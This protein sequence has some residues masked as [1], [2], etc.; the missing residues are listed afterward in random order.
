MRRFFYQANFCAECGNALPQQRA[1]R[2]RYFCAPCAQQ[3]R[4]HSLRYRVLLPLGILLVLGSWLVV[5]Q[6]AFSHDISPPANSSAVVTAWDATAQS[7]PAQLSQPETAQPAAFCGARTKRGTPCRRLVQAG[8]RC[9]Q[10]RGKPSLLTA[11][12]TNT[13]FPVVSEAHQ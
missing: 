10:H 8:Q 2:P 4:E 6:A 3:R 9:P 1:W 13:A 12:T 7:N 5:K 11:P